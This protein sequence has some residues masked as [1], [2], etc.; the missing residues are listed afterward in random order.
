MNFNLISKSFLRMAISFYLLGTISAHSHLIPAGS[1][2]INVV[3]SEIIMLLGL[4]MTIFKGPSLDPDGF[5]DGE[6]V[7]RYQS[8]MIKQLQDIFV[9][10]HNGVI[11]LIKDT[12]FFISPK[13][14]QTNRVYQMEWLIK[15]QIP[16]LNDQN[17]NVVLEINYQL[18]K[19]D[20]NVQVKHNEQSE[21][22]IL[23]ESHP[24]YIFFK[25]RL[26]TFMSYISYGFEHIMFGFDHILF[27]L[28]LLAT[29]LTLKRWITLLSTF[30]VAHGV[31]YGLSSLNI[32][33][34]S[35]SIVEP[36]IAASI[37]YVG[38]IQL[39]KIEPKLRVEIVLVFC[40]GLIHGLGFASA[41]QTGS[42]L[43]DRFPIATIL[44][45]NLGVEAGQI[46]IA[47]ILLYLYW[48]ASRESSLIK[49]DSLKRFFAMTGT[50]LGFYWLVERVF[51]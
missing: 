32:V 9:L 46:L 37:V 36:L 22:A 14:E 41:M 43:V 16:N 10:K 29:K 31:T 6:E 2:A 44:G 25:N 40:F 38:V 19:Q 49:P 20:L 26:G 7:K 47:L 21:V 42:N 34:M 4:P 35:V 11:P 33:S 18:L 45:F 51:F 48:I 3:D 23:S 27:L 30:T 1:A 13:S 8:E 15:Y 5:F 50:I 12:Q 28:V 39:L 17:P 24:K